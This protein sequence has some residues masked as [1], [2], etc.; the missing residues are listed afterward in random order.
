MVLD[1]LLNHDAQDLVTVSLY[2][3]ITIGT[4]HLC[5]LSVAYC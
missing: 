4:V 1:E 2:I 5:S 3:Q